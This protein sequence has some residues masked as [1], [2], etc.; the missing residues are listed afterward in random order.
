MVFFHKEKFLWW[1]LILPTAVCF[2]L[3]LVSKLT[4][5]TVQ[6]CDVEY[7]YDIVKKVTYYEPYTTWESRTCYRTVKCGK[8]TVSVPYDCSYCDENNSQYVAYTELGN[9]YPISKEHYNRIINKWG[10]VYFEELNRDINYHFN[11][12]SDG[13]AYSSNFNNKPEHGEIA[14]YSVS[15]VNKVKLAK[16]LFHFIDLDDDSA[17]KLGLYEYPI[18]YDE[19]KTECLIGFKDDNRIIEDR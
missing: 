2:V 7:N 6:S 18:K 14:T 15:F 1:E 16:D 4:I 5:E 11:C 8:S 9:S 13:D 10:K 17:K 3:I 19:Y 12:G